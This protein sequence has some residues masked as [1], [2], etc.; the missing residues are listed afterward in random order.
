MFCLIDCNN[1]YASCERLFRPDLY[2][3]P[4]IVLSNNDGCVVARS[5]EAKDLGISMGV[6]FFKVKDICKK[7]GVVSFSSNYT[8]Y[9][10]LSS[11][12]M[13][14]IQ[15][16]WPETE[17]YS[18]DEV[19][20][21]LK[22]LPKENHIAFCEQ[23]QK[24]I[25]KR[26]GIPTSIGIGPTKTLAKLANYV[27]KKKLKTPVFNITNELSWLSKIE[28]GDIWGVGSRLQKKLNAAG[29]FTAKDLSEMV[30]SL[31][32][33][34][35]S[36]VLQR[37][38]LELQGISCLSLEPIEPQKSIMSSCSFGSLQTNYVYLAESIAHHCATAAKKLREQG[39]IA[40]YISVFIKSN[41]FRSDLK[42]YSPV[43]KYKLINP[44]DDTR[45]LTK[46]AK[47]CLRQIF[48]EGIHY[49]KAGILLEEL[50]PKN[51]RQQDLLNPQSE[52]GINQSEQIMKIMGSVNKKYGERTLRLA[53]EGFNKS[54][55]M[56]RQLKSPN[57]TT[58]WAELPLVKAS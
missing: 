26:T 13:Q 9:G 37:T 51:Y 2:N 12:V 23:L 25:L 49:S 58:S 38:V 27:A 1:F 15:E 24:L 10:D 34:L 22:T 39:S 46:I 7:H 50:I 31:A 8:L 40:Q 5:N 48:K 3:K 33:K 28:V 14:V 57:Y 43:V 32:K 52:E 11:R 36:V 55:S 4:I 41:P 42:Q 6:P 35:Y 17:I 56:K 20:L 19:F 30:P 29:I 21:D 45:E 54:W 16:N 47:N 44:T 18:I 53:A